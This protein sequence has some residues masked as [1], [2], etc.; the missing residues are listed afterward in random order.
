V[1][2]HASSNLVRS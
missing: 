1:I 2:T